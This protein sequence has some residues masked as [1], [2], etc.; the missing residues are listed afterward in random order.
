M[1]S[2]IVTPDK[3]DDQKLTFQMSFIHIQLKG[4]MSWQCHCWLWVFSLDTEVPLLKVLCCTL[5]STSLHLPSMQSCEK[6]SD[7][8]TLWQK[9]FNTVFYQVPCSSS[10]LAGWFSVSGQILMWRSPF[11]GMTS[12]FCRDWLESFSRMELLSGHALNDEDCWDKE[13]D[14][15]IRKAAT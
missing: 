9:N 5:P 13:H 7:R 3:C 12:V 8:K 11:L 15:E 4:L 14:C 6:L 1:Y 2:H 10:R